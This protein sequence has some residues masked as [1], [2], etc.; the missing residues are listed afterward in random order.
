MECFFIIRKV[1]FAHDYNN[2]YCTHDII[3]LCHFA[4]SFMKYLSGYHDRVSVGGETSW[5]E[6]VGPGNQR[7]EEQ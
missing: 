1:M 6:V 7:G 2:I 3:M 5:Y 4:V